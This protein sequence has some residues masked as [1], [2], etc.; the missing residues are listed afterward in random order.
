VNKA[1]NDLKRKLLV[2]LS[3]IACL[4][5]SNDVLIMSLMTVCVIASLTF[6]NKVTMQHDEIAAFN[7]NPT[8]KFMNKTSKTGIQTAFSRG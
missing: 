7:W 6:A 2:M 1:T 3:L 5:I 8:T 4:L